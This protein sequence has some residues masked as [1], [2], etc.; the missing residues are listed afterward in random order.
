MFSSS[1][2][3]RRTV[4]LAAATLAALTVFAL[5][6]LGAGSAHGTQRSEPVAA[7]PV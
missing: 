1:P 5:G 3:L 4:A 2:G 7:A 6:S